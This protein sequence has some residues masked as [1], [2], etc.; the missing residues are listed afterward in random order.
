MR[1]RQADEGDP[2]QQHRHGLAGEE[3][4]GEGGGEQQRRPTS[5]AARRLPERLGGEQHPGEPRHRDLEVERARQ[6]QEAAAAGEGGRGKGRRTEIG[7]Q[8]PGEQ[9]RADEGE[10]RVQ[11]DQDADSQVRRQRQQQP[12]DRVE[13]SVVRVRENG[14]A[15][16]DQRVPPRQPGSGEGTQR[17][18][19]RQVEG[20]D[21]A[22]REHCAR[23]EQRRQQGGEQQHPWDEEQPLPARSSGREST[24]GLRRSS[25]RGGRR[26]HH[27]TGWRRLRSVTAAA[28]G[29][30]SRRSTRCPG[31]S[32]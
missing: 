17:R 19:Q 30:R 7:V 16:I 10:D 24:I 15:G 5:P 8:P 32:R 23:I 4:Q 11:D 13:G 29:R 12:G 26:D 9:E 2:R 3:L 27:R 14:L 1:Q 31:D 25:R 20:G 22:H 28:S 21:V 6:G 18:A